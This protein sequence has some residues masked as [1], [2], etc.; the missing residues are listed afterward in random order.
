[1]IDT[2]PTDM[3]EL[4]RRLRATCHAVIPHLLDDESTIS[5]KD[6]TVSVALTARREA[7]RTRTVSI[8][9]AAVLVV[10]AA[11][12]G[13]VLLRN[14]SD[15]AT[16][17]GQSN[18]QPSVSLPCDVDGCHGFARLAVA[19]G[20]SDYYIGGADLGT[21][22]VDLSLFDTIAWCSALDAAG[23]T[24]LTLQGAAGVEQVTYNTSSTPLF[25]DR[26]QD[27]IRIG[28]TFTDIS[29]QQY[30]RQWGTTKG[31]GAVSPLTVRGHVGARFMA[32][33]DPAL[34]WQ[35]R[36]G[37]LVW[38]A[39]PPQRAGDLD[40][41]AVGVRVAAGP[42]TIAAQVVVPVGTEHYTATDND[43]A[44]LLAAHAAVQGAECIGY[45]FIDSCG[46]TIASR[47][48]LSTTSDHTVVAGSTPSGVALVHVTTSDGVVTTGVPVAA[49]PGFTS[50]YFDIT[51]AGTVRTVEWLDA[52]GNL[53]A[54]TDAAGVAQRNVTATADTTTDVVPTTA[55]TVSSSGS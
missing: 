44:G 53:L 39:V 11:A 12:V 6:A 29:P 16:Q 36:P 54:S 8:A 28:T 27:Q 15:L 24:C 49:L 13:A 41:I 40:A 42:R 30:A 14:G 35:E 4:E 1:M 55:V 51:V 3:T 20:A 48:F 7:H 45:Q 50:R 22:T 38:V 43:A 31:G 46:Q 23:T 33:L 19:P 5:T 9:A 32:E 52:A 26:A 2:D 37:V 17:S 18:P 34:V 25:G 10:G 21:P 47:T